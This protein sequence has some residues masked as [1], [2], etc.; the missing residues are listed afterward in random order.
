MRARDE[1]L[2]LRREKIFC[3][4]FILQQLAE[5]QAG[6]NLARA[7]QAAIAWALRYVIRNISLARSTSGECISCPSSLCVDGVTEF[8][9]GAWYLADQ[10]FAFVRKAITEELC[11]AFLLGMIAHEPSS[12]PRTN[13][14]AS[15]SYHFAHKAAPKDEKRTLA[16]GLLVGRAGRSSFQFLV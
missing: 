12:M 3:P 9:A 13:W 8:F 7:P 1:G 5:F 11:A 4:S 10:P 2:V 14:Y 6:S 15:L 16:M